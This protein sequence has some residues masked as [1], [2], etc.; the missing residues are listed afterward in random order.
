MRNK[1]SKH[2]EYEP[3]E[4][5]IEY[6]APYELK[7]ATKGSAGYDLQSMETVT[8]PP[9]KSKL[10][11]TG[12]FLNFQA[13]EA[14]FADSFEAQVRSRSGLAYK[15]SVFVL[16]SP[17]TIDSDYTGEIKVILFNAGEQDYT[18]NEGDRIAQLVFCE[19]PSVTMSKVNQVKHSE[20]R[21]SGGFGS[22][23]V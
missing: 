13:Y 6:T 20:T 2:D 21:G 15:H 5:G 14:P 12:V 3:T 17:G 22:T 19:L 16:N 4:C 8:I 7:K 10:V 18:I 11:P 23:G 1:M 9:G